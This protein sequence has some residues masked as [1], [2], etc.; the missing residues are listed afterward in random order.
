MID[1][2]PIILATQCNLIK[3]V[4]IPSSLQ[5]LT[6]YFKRED[7][8]VCTPGGGDLRRYVGK[9]VGYL[10]TEKQGRAEAKHAAIY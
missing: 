8:R 10:L 5:V 4:N 3:R 6:S 1:S 9:R 2:H 7:D